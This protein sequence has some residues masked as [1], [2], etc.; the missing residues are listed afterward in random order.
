MSILLV[1]LID[2]PY[3]RTDSLSRG[4]GDVQHSGR[5]ADAVRNVFMAGKALTDGMALK[6]IAIGSLGLAFLM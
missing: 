3:L 2:T 6:A 4:S 1:L 5:A